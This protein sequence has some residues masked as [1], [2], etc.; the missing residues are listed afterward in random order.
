MELKR[1]VSREEL[2]S[3]MLNEFEALL[4][5]ASAGGAVL[6]AWKERLETLNRRVTVTFREQTYEGTAEDVDEDGNLLLRTDNGDLMTVE[7][8]EVSLR[9]PAAAG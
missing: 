5:D 6:A 7:A 9:P 3:S 8:G 1:E 4:A 2:M